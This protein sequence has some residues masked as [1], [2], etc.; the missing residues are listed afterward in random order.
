MANLHVEVFIGEASLYLGRMEC[1]LFDFNRARRSSAV[2]YS[3]LIKL[4]F[5]NQYVSDI[6]RVALNQSIV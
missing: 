6:P 1:G 4:K 3:I 2:V 5:G